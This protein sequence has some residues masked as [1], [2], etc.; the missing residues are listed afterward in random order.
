[1][2]REEP[3][4]AKAAI[5]VAARNNKQNI[6]RDRDGVNVRFG[7]LVFIDV[8]FVEIYIASLRVFVSAVYPGN[9]RRGSELFCARRRRPASREA[10]I[11]ATSYAETTVCQ[12]SSDVTRRRVERLWRTSRQTEGIR[13]TEGLIRPRARSINR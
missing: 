11:F 3:I 13:R 9:T 6:R 10:S 2:A 7:F 8:G 1:M 5:A 4:A 12:E